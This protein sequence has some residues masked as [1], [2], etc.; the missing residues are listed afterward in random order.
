MIRAAKRLE[1]IPVP[2]TAVCVIRGA[3][4]RQ[5]DVIC[6][7]APAPSLLSICTEP[8]GVASSLPR[9]T[10]LQTTMVTSRYP[11]FILPFAAADHQ[12]EKKRHYCRQGT[13]HP[14]RPRKEKWHWIG[15][16]LPDCF[17]YWFL[18]RSSTPFQRGAQLS[19]AQHG[20]ESSQPS[21]AQPSTA[22]HS[23][24]QLST[25]RP[26]PAQ[27]GPAQKSQNHTQ[28]THSPLPTPHSPLP[29]PSP[30]LAQ[31]SPAARTQLTWC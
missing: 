4:S 31:G 24:A 17:S 22:Q 23:T 18:A 14:Q 12:Q 13:P 16:W 3:R 30:R 8:V 27:H 2:V 7:P 26:S 6:P 25:A 29:T 21:T 9:C 15:G 28:Q 10:A 20:P 5:R 11:R 1:K 19:P